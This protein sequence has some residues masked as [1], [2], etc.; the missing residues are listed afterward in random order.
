VTKT[1]KAK[2]SI[3]LDVD[4]IKWVDEF[5]KAGIYTNRS[6]AIEQ[7]LKKVRQQMV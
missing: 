1:A 6:E 5:V 2:I 4:L 7:L 3:S